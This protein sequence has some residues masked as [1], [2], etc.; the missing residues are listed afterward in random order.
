MADDMRE[1]GRMPSEETLRASREVQGREN[2]P[3]PSVE[4][5][6]EANEQLTL[7]ALQAYEQADRLALRYRD[8]VEGLDAIVWEAEVDPWRYTFV[9]QRAA[10]FLG[11]PPERWYQEPN[12]WIDLIHPEDRAQA[13]HTWHTAV[14]ERRPFR[15]EYRALASDGRV[16]WLE[17]IV[18]FRLTDEGVPQFYGLLIDITGSKR[19]EQRLHEVIATQ[20]ALEGQLHERVQELERFH[21]MVVGRE[22]KMIAVEKELIRLQEQLARLTS[23]KSHPSHE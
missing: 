19:T 12:F 2:E 11:Y 21:D 5:L 15:M 9:S 4:P 22:L 8:L 13:L 1:G 17:L 20:K 23:Q 16:I 7:A 6:R 10:T 3:R 18:H 14:S